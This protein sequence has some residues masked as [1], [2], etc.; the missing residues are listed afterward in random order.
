MIANREESK[1]FNLVVNSLQIIC[2]YI[3]W[4]THK[5]LFS[6]RKMDKIRVK[7]IN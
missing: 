7:I 5:E 6:T 1:M 3:S 4:T 2:G